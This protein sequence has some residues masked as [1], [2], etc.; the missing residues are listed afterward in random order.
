[1]FGASLV[2]AKQRNHPLPLGIE[3]Q[4]G[5]VAVFVGQEWSNQTGDGTRGSD[6]DQHPALLPVLLEQHRS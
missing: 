5:R 4:D 2:A 6:H 1:L 3:H